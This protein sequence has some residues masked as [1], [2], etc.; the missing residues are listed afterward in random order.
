[1]IQDKVV[2]VTFDYNST[3]KHTIEITITG[4][5][6]GQTVRRRMSTLMPKARLIDMTEVLTDTQLELATKP[7]TQGGR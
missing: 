7:K 3:E 4:E 2:K 6:I 5:Q 1:M